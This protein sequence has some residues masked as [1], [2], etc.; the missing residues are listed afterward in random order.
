MQHELDHFYKEIDLQKAPKRY[1]DLIRFIVEHKLIRHVITIQRHF[2]RRK[3]KEWIY[4]N[5]NGTVAKAGQTVKVDVSFLESA[6]T[7]ERG[8]LECILF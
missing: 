3:M 6:Q 8:Q 1:R 4:K 5:S 2:R 7:K